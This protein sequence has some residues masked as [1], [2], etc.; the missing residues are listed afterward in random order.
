MFPKKK[1]PTQK[2]CT[3]SYN[4]N[5]SSSRRRRLFSKTS[6]SSTKTAAPLELAFSSIKS[7]AVEEW[8][9]RWRTHTPHVQETWPKE[10]NEN[11]TLDSSAASKLEFVLEIA[12]CLTAAHN[13]DRCPILAKFSRIPI[14]K[15]WQLGKQ[16]Q[17]GKRKRNQ[18][19]NLKHSN[20]WENKTERERKRE[21]ER[22]NKKDLKLEEE[23]GL[24]WRITSQESATATKATHPKPKRSE[25]ERARERGEERRRRRSERARGRGKRCFRKKPHNVK[26]LVKEANV[27]AY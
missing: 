22:E 15:N 23:N 7:T 26:A 1:L 11:F 16:E 12:A 20:Q 10:G 27:V 24:E 17:T 2:P 4:N 8:C 18:R 5:S 25:S 19:Q 3:P 13:P 21:R 14:L 6:S 9:W